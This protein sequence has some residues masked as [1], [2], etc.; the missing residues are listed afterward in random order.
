M[1][2]LIISTL[3][4]ETIKTE[5]MQICLAVC[6]SQRWGKGTQPCSQAKRKD[7]PHP[8]GP[9]VEAA[10]HARN[11]VVQLVVLVTP[12]HTALPNTLPLRLIRRKTSHGI[13]CGLLFCACCWNSRHA[14]WGWNFWAPPTKYRVSPRFACAIR[15]RS[16]HVISCQKI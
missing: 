1:F 10:Q 8:L 5:S 4:C 2:L 16:I 15:K 13:A 14:Q 9:G 12:G 3:R 6:W 11:L 7:H